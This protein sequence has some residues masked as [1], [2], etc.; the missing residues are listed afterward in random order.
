MGLYLIIES[1]GK[2]IQQIQTAISS[3]DP[4]PI[5]KTYQNL[6]EFYKETE[7]Q[8]KITDAVNLAVVEFTHKKL[9]EWNHEF[10]KFKTSLLVPE[11]TEINQDVQILMSSFDEAN[12]QHK[13]L[14]SLPVNNF[15]FKPYDTLILKETINAALTFKKRLAPIELKA[16]KS[17]STIGILKDIELVSVSELGF[18]TFSEIQ[19]PEGSVSKYFCPI[20]SYNKKQSAWAQCLHSFPHPTKENTFVNQFQ[21]YGVETAFLMNI[22]K[23]IALNKLRKT[24]EFV[25]DLTTEEATLQIRIGLLATDLEAAAKLQED[26][27]HHFK[28]VEVEIIHFLSALD[29]PKRTNLQT[30]DTIL[31]MSELKPDEFSKLMKPGAK[32]FWLNT[33]MED[34]EERKELAAF[35]KDLNYTPLDRSYLYKK[36]KLHHPEI[37]EKEPSS[38]LTVACGLEKMKSANLL[39][40]SEISEIFVTFNYTRELALKTT[41]EFIFLAEDETNLVELPAFCHFVEPAQGEKG[42]FVQQ[43]VFFGMTDHYL[44][45]IRLWLMQ[46]YIAKNQKE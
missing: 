4:Q 43:F 39:K 1:D 18:V 27:V 10:V 16:N 37:L 6:E 44:K 3:L 13:T 23:Y 11:N 31:N 7:G 5:F 21:F 25:F 32:H 45:Q 2:A 38:F 9:Q 15:I 30:F 22:R 46:D 20:F 40:I 42:K 12:V 28:N 29:L 33:K 8:K 41:R 34:D 35:Y 19:L 26:L 36:L 14:L 24:T 17:S